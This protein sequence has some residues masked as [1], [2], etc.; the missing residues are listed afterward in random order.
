MNDSARFPLLTAEG[1]RLLR[2][3]REHPHA[4]KYTA[5]CGN[6]LTAGYLRRVRDYEAALD[7]SPKG[8]TPGTHPPWLDDFVAMGYRDV[9]FYRRYGDRPPH[10]TDIPTIDRSHLSREIW[11][12]VPD[13]APLDDLILYVTSGTTGHPLTIL[14]HPIVGADYTPL[15]KAALRLHGI[16]L[17]AGAGQICCVLVGWQK[18]AYTYPS[19]TPHQDEAGH[20]KL[21]L[22]PDDWRDPDDRAKFLDDCNPELY[23]GDPIAF[24]ELMKLPLTTRPRALISTATTL[25]P[26]LRHE[27][28]SHFGCP[29]LDVYSMN[30][31]GPIAVALPY[32]HTSQT[33]YLLQHRLYMEILDPDGEPTLPGTRGEIT[34]TGGLNFYLPLLR[35]R[36]GDYA[37]LEFRGSQP[38]L[39]D[40]EGRPPTTFRGT[41]GSLIN[42]LDVTAALKP[43]AI[44][45]FTFH[46]NA[47]GSLIMKLRRMA[48]D[49][50]QIRAALLALFG[51]D[52]ALIVEAVDSLG[53]ASDKV[54]QYTSAVE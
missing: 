36:T 47:D 46:Q 45:Q 4:P 17:Q 43:F 52:Q 28:E 53:G 14:S 24:A 30:E 15:Y 26:G 41:N 31:S 20:L 32:S 38:V 18:Q 51:S 13:S 33:Y 44:P 42:T 21:N 34:L 35:Y 9:P 2:W 54:I 39:V 7:S 11:S 40:L 3:M 12:F 48:M 22:H 23:T 10:F 27:L 6:R 25:L 37:R 50:T 16:E 19:V 29:V 1:R 49:T 5:V 8:W